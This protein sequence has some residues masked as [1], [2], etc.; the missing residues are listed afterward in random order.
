MKS[1]FPRRIAPAALLLLSLLSASPARAWIYPEHR[2]IAGKAV[3]DMSPAER[4]TLDALWAEARQGHEERLC[5]VP[6]A[7][8]QGPK[9]TCIDWA[10]WPAISG[11]HSCSAGEMLGTVLDSD[12]IVKVA[13]VCSRLEVA[14]ATAKNPIDLRNRLVRSDLELARADKEYASRAGANN[15]HFLLARSSDDA[16]EY[17]ME[18]VRNGGELNALGTWIRAHVAALRLAA[19]LG[20]GRVAPADRPALARTILALEAYGA[21][22]LEDSFASGHVAGCWG[23]VATRKGTHDYYNE[24]GV[25]TRTWDGK[26][27]VLYGD[28]RMRPEDRDRAAPTIRASLLQVLAALQPGNELAQIAAEL[29]LPPAEG[30]PAFDT[31]KSTELP[32]F[33]KLPAGLVEPLKSILLTTPVAGRGKDASLPRFRSE[34]GTFIGLSSGIRGAWASG[35]LESESSGSR[36][37]GTLDLSVRVGLGLEALLGDMADGQV[38]LQ[39]GI[40]YAAKQKSSCDGC[41]YSQTV[42]SLFPKLPARTGISTRLRIPFWLIPG[43]LLVATPVLA[44]TAPHTLEK[45]AIV[46]GDGGLIPWQA[47]FSSFMGRVQFCLGRE[48]GATFYGYSGGEDQFL[49]LTTSES[50]AQKLVPV[51][52][53]SIDFDLPIVEIRPYRGFSE[54]QTSAL[55]FQIGAGADVPQKVTALYPPGTP[56][57]DLKTSYYGYVR[58]FFDWRRYF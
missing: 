52:L 42:Q 33:P 36:L 39:G 38:F 29:P 28:A 45:M 56:A 3:A 58:V 25:D 7:A 11:D 17:L 37:A 50:G 8:D 18:S 46:A 49:A 13:G 23:D 4:E 21:H 32:A 47:G 51:S 12:W 26:P 40:A 54:N 53:R 30:M 35:G 24:H 5:P 14:M 57:P 43:D 27:I 10:A 48:V 2:A 16:L 6:W 19:E 22:F 20:S 55:L 15:V 34:V 1:G 41:T 44:F 31:C 9:P